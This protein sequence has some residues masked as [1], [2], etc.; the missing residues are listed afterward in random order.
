[1]GDGAE[2][3]G[4]LGDRS[5]PFQGLVGAES[6]KPSTPMKHSRRSWGPRDEVEGSCER[7]SV[8]SLA[9]DLVFNF[10]LL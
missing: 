7:E 3:Q 4:L 5:V 10:A 8:Y 2:G 9:R 6:S 1:M